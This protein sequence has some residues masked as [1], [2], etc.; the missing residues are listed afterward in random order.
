MITREVRR[1]R[2]V[3]RAPTPPPIIKRVVERAPT[4]EAPVLERVIIRPQAQEIVERVIEQ[5]R[6]PPPRIIQKEMHEEAP[7]PIVR[8]RVIKVYR[9]VRQQFSQSG[10]A[11]YQNGGGNE[12]PKGYRTHSI[13]GSTGRPSYHRSYS[14][15]SSF[16]YVPPQQQQQPQ[17]TTSTAVPQQVMMMPQ[18]V[19]A[20]RPTQQMMYRPVMQPM[21]QMQQQPAQL[22]N[23]GGQQ[24]PQTNNYIFPF[25]QQH[26]PG[27]GGMQFAYRPMVMQQQQPLAG[28]M[29]G[30]SGAGIHMMAGTYPGQPQQQMFHQPMAHQMVY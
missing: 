25:H 8:T 19:G 17:M 2:D 28:A 7:P 6:T 1:P 5:P 29:S 11:Y 10:S 21:M 16:E 26:Q 4:P 13:V 27:A 30:G 9:P 15:S 12:F 3:I 22:I 18:Q 23:Y 20:I 24:Q 14:S